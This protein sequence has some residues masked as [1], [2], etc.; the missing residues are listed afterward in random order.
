MSTGIPS[1]CFVP[2]FTKT[3]TSNFVFVFLGEIVVF[4]MTDAMLKVAELVA[5]LA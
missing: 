3:C 1:Q 5:S 4:S 2:D